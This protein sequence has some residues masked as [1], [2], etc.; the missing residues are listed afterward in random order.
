MG[1]R[2]D[3]GSISEAVLALGMNAYFLNDRASAE[4]AAKV[5]NVWFVDPKTR[6]NPILE[7]G[8]AVRGHNTGRGTGIIDSRQQSRDLVDGSSSRVLHFF[9]RRGRAAPPHGVCA[10]SRLARPEPGAAGRE[11]SA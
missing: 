1:N 5:L 4:R 2:G 11:L 3:I 10:L 9:G 7:S 8:Q 6:M